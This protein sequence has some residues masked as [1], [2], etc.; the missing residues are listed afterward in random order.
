M[1]LWEGVGLMKK[2]SVMAFLPGVGSTLR[3]SVQQRCEAITTR[4]TRCRR[5]AT[6]LVYDHPYHHADAAP[7][8]Y[9]C[10]LHWEKIVRTH[11]RP[12][13]WPR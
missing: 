12:R 5:P 13:W 4:A 7:T 2:M 3:S 8:R 9:C 10:E 6:C 1:Q 11:A